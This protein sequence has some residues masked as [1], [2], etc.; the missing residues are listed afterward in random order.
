MG[1]EP[2][3]YTEGKRLFLGKHNVS[4]KTGMYPTTEED[5]EVKDL[6]LRTSDL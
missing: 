1:Q 4:D 2:L 3:T 6:F 5:K